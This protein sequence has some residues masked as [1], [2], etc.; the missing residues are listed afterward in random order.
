MSIINFFDEKSVLIIGANGK[1]GR[2]LIEK[3]L[4]STAHRCAVMNKDEK[5]LIS[6]KSY[7]KDDRLRFFLGDMRDNQRLMRAFDGV[8]VIIVCDCFSNRDLLDYNPMEAIQSNVRAFENLVNSA[9]ERAVSSV[10]VISQAD[11]FQK[12]DLYDVTRM[13]AEKIVISA[14]GLSSFRRT[15]FSVMR[16]ADIWDYPDQELQISV[17]NTNTEACSRFVNRGKTH[18]RFGCSVKDVCDL[19]SRALLKSIGG[20]IL[21]PKLKGYKIED[22]VRFLWEKFP[23][24]RVD[25]VKN[26][27][28]TLNFLTEA[29]HIKESDFF[30]L[31]CPQDEWW[32]EALFFKNYHQVK[33]V[34]ASFVYRACDAEIVKDFRY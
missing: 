9:I 30:Y 3:V 10:F 33:A 18:Y 26:S 7:F 16:I 14:N 17:E 32:D 28:T 12:K 21:I 2:A 22:Y 29:E 13:C 31:I 23:T 1:L 5:S 24:D 8:D 19:T 6:L 4:E 11:F 20:E 34:S 27:S 25:V 15:K